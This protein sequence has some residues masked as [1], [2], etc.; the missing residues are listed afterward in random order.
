[1]TESETA[2]MNARE[3]AQIHGG[4]GFMNETQV[5]RFWRDA[6]VLEIG[7]G[8]SELQQMIIARELGL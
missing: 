8:A 1:L 2:V 7:E 5:A 6:K 4:Y 3:A